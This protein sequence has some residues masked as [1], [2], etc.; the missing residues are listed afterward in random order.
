MEFEKTLQNALKTLETALEQ[1]E[2][3]KKDY[4]RTI[5]RINE[6]LNTVPATAKVHF[7]GG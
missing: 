3:Q 4:E 7:V 5:N 2:T 1:H 6:V